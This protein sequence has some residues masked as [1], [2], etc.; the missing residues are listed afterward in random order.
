MSHNPGYRPT[1]TLDDP[2]RRDQ[3]RFA[4]TEAGVGASGIRPRNTPG[5]F[6]AKGHDRQLDEMKKA[7][8]EVTVIIAGDGLTGKIV[9]KDKW[10]I[11]LDCGRG[12]H[13]LIYKHAIERIV[14]S[15]R[16]EG[17]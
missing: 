3:E 13:H 12:E 4:R 8:Q 2:V 14:F 17:H 5:K 9:T 15:P 1:I 10:T 11:T 7:N 6:V 16:T